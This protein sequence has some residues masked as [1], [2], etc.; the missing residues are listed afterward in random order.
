M[1]KSLKKITFFCSLA[2]FFLI[3]VDLS[4]SQT[5]NVQRDKWVVEG[6]ARIKKEEKKEPQNFRD[7]NS[8]DE[9]AMLCLLSRNSCVQ[10]CRRTYKEVKEDSAKNK[11]QEYQT[12]LFLK[13][14]CILTCNWNRDICVEEY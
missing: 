14:K 2:L 3:S 6:K 13:R 12:L 10:K 5:V 4:F 8:N 1:N 7:I 9:R 11:E